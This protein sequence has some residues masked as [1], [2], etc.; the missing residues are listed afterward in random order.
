MVTRT[1]KA[2]IAGVRRPRIFK[3]GKRVIRLAIARDRDKLWL[4]AWAV[5]NKLV[6]NKSI[7]TVICHHSRGGIVKQ[8]LARVN[9]ERSAISQ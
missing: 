7:P 5:R 9:Q 1:I 6:K 2:K 3:T 4:A 8:K